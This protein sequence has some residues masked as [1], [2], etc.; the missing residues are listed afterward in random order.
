MENLFVPGILVGIL[1]SAF[2]FFITFG[3]GSQDLKIEAVKHGA[4]T[5]QVNE[6]GVT[7]FTWKE[8]A[9]QK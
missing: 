5:W 7:T 9:E 6:R 1:I 4:A 8:N 2:I 3:M